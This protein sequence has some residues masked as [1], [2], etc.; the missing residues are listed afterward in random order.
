MLQSILQKLKHNRDDSGE[1]PVSEDE[2]LAPVASQMCD[3]EDVYFVLDI[4]PGIIVVRIID[5]TVATIILLRYR[6][7]QISIYVP[8]ITS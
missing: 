2:R 6:L 1:P 4:V 8:D 5:L 3:Y 7:S